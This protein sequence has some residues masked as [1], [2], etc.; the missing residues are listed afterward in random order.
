ME[1]RASQRFSKRRFDWSDGCTSLQTCVQHARAAA[2]DVAARISYSSLVLLP[3]RLCLLDK[4]DLDRA[5]CS[6]RTCSAPF[7]AVKKLL[8]WIPP[9]LKE[10][11][12]Q[13]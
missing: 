9:V 6:S 2:C 4:Q 13:H 8:C 3:W 10:K 12:M 7:K 5:C 1:R 11:L